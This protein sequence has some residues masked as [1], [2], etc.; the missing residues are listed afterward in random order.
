MN[1]TAILV[2]LLNLLFKTSSAVFIDSCYLFS[3]PYTTDS[4]NIFLV[5][6]SVVSSSPCSVD[7]FSLAYN[8]DTIGV[9][10][11][12]EAGFIQSTCPRVDTFDLG[13]RL[14]NPIKVIAAFL[15][16]SDGVCKS[17]SLFQDSFTLQVT[18]DYNTISDLNTIGINFHPNPA[19]NKITVENPSV[20]SSLQILSADG[21]VHMQRSVTQQ[22]NFE[23][24]VS[25]LPAGIYF[26]QLWDGKQQVVRKFV[27][28]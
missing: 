7:D 28:Q 22:P 23:I 21:R 1:K 3:R 2:I 16:N 19:T 4:S 13:I 6:H 11:C 10:V 27:K 20:F 15:Q 17:S 24:D 18:T 25:V 26:L 12:Y 14:N 9:T 5:V 8:D